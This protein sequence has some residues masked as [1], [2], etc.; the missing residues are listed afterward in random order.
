MLQRVVAKRLLAGGVGSESA[1]ED[2][3]E[4]FYHS[5]ATVEAMRALRLLAPHAN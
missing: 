2:G 1:R 4:S 5:Y 3:M